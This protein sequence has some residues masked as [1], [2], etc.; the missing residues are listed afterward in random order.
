M[1]GKTVDAILFDYGGVLAEEGF[2]D[3]LVT[4]AKEQEL[5]AEAMPNE[6]ML[7]VYDSGFVL[8]SGTASD[9]WELLHKRTGLA[10]DNDELSK[11]ILSGFVIRPWMIELVGQLHKQGYITGILSDQTY[12]LDTLNERDHFFDVFDHVYNSYYMGKGKRDSSLFNDVAKDLG[13]P[14]S[15]ILF[16]DDNEANVCRARDTGMQAI[17]Y[18]DRQSFIS[19]LKQLTGHVFEV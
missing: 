16:I 10:G 9:F 17:Q 7:A 15:K 5:N 18:V 8:G 2:R 4:F 11:R 12:W 3:G 19:E 14:L 6:G 1:T 13:L